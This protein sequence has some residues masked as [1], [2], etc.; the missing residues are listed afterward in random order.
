MVCEMSNLGLRIADCGLRL[1][2][3]VSRQ[4]LRIWGCGMADVGNELAA[5]KL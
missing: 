1:P 5:G 4:G 3:C 2:D